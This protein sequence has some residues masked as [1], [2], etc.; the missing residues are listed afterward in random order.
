MTNDSYKTNTHPST[1]VTI[2]QDECISEAAQKIRNNGVGC[3]IVIDTCGKLTGIVTERDIVS[4]AAANLLDFEK[5]SVSEIMTKDVIW[6]SPDIEP[7]KARELMAANHIR[8]LP[9]VQDGKAVRMYS[10]R[11]IVQEQL[12]EGRMAA[13]QV[14]MLSACLKS[15]NLVEITNMVTREVPRLFDAK[16]CMLYFQ[17]DFSDP[18][19]ALPASYNNCLCPRQCLKDLF[20][21][22]NSPERCRLCTDSLPLICQ[23]EG[24]AWPRIIIQLSIDKIK[25]IIPKGTG[26]LD[27]HLCM[28]GL[29]HSKAVNQSLLYYKAKL[30]KD[31]LNAHL[32]NVAQYQDAR[33]ASLTDALTKVGSRQYF[34]DMLDYECARADRYDR[35]FTIA[36]IDVDNFKKLNDTFGHIAGDYALKQ[37]AECMKSQ[38]RNS[39]IIARFGGDEFVIILSETQAQDA[40]I[41]L[42]RVQNKVRQIKIGDNFFVAV[43]CGVAQL[44]PGQTISGTELIRRADIALYKAKNEGKDCIRIW[45][46]NTSPTPADGRNVY[47]HQVLQE[48]FS[49]LQ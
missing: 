41:M 36:I 21:G 18:K 5:T 19:A 31:I 33:V 37:L 10:I 15:T 7:R 9:I 2:N 22:E 20:K 25:G 46:E 40:L 42:E 47:P 48:N 45:N 12:I 4:R 38:K 32:T 3:L 44:I 29:D 26:R 14:A 30:V 11:D 27:G 23:R 34:E 28:C 35:P 13:E 24:A 1:I 6:C 17:E 43:S 39:D 8:H 49:P 16:R